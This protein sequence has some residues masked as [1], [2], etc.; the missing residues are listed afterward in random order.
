MKFKEI[1]FKY[2]AKQNNISI[3]QFS[4]YVE[5]FAEGDI[6]KTVIVSSYDDYFVNESGYFIRYRHNNHSQ[7][8]TLKRKLNDN[9]NN[10]RIEVNLQIQPQNFATVETFSNL[11]GYYHNF[12]IYKTCKIYW[13]GRVVLCYYVVFDKNMIET[14]RFIEIEA[15][16]ESEF[17][18]ETEALGVIKYYEERLS[19]LGISSKKRLKK[20]LFEIYKV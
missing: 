2:D 7:E 17:V 6:N 12:C 19:P 3:E 1:E 20:S 14:N 4:N 5:K 10:E 18:D 16:E 15:N 9:N 13:I 8:L 11:L